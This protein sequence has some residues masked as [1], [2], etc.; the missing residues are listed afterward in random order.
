MSQKQGQLT[1]NAS[2]L[3]ILNAIR[4]LVSQG[5]LSSADADKAVS[6]IAEKL[7]VSLLAV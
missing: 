6:R 1:A 5:K 2:Y 7:G 3:G 4:W